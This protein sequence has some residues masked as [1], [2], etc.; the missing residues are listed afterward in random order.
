[1]HGGFLSFAGVI[2]LPITIVATFLGGFIVKKFKLQVTGMAK[3][4]C[5]TFLSAYLFNLLYF[6]SNCEVLQVAGLT[7]NYSGFVNLV[8]VWGVRAGIPSL[9]KCIRCALD[10]AVYV[11]AQP[12]T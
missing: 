2:V 9:N 7:V 8:H 1:M 3:F 11:A 10:T 4:T 6:A 5:I 12:P